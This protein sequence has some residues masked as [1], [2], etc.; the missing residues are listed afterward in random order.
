MNEFKEVTAADLRAIRSEKG[1][2][3]GGIGA[4]LGITQTAVSKIEKGTRALSESEKALL[5]WYFFGILPSRIA[6]T[7]SLQGCLEFTDQEWHVLGRMAARV[8]QT[9]AQF[10]T[11]TIRL[12]IQRNTQWQEE[13][14]IH[15]LNKVPEDATP[16]RTDGNGSQSGKA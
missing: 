7:A 6:T 8:G 4:L 2:N 1:M 3:Q 11:A 5:D 10:I 9:H 15:L 12:D 16:Y 14:Q 13:K